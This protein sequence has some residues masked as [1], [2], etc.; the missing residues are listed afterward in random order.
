VDNSNYL[1]IPNRDTRV[2]RII[3]EKRL[4]ELFALKKN[5]LVKPKK[6][7]DPWENC[8][9]GCDLQLR[10]GEKARF[11]FQDNLYGQCWTLQSASDAMWQIYSP[12]SDALRVR[13]TV[14]K[15]ADSLWRCRGKWAPREVFIG[16]VQYLRDR[17]LKSFAAKALRSEV[18]RPSVLQVA[19]TLLVKRRAFKHEREVR[20][21]F[22]PHKDRA[23]SERFPYDVDD[24]NELI[25]QIMIDPR[26]PATEA[27]ALK[28]RIKSK[29]G[30]AGEIKR[31]LLYAP[32]RGWIF[33]L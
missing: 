17:E 22:A 6:W 20:L 30:F 23:G 8:I 13:S 16:R 7:K 21:I 2:Y 14:R 31:S 19:K 18:G 9:L 29:T 25:D 24:P 28:R 26:F 5:V 4:F 33:R 12:N 15:L 32:P 11:H 27:D 3:S 10:N 1:D